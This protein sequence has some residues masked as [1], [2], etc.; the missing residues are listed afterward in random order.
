M[1]EVYYHKGYSLML[2]GRASRFYY[3]SLTTKEPITFETMVCATKVHFETE[4]NRQLYMSDWRETTYPRIIAANPSKSRL[5]CLQ[6]LYD[7]L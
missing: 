5:E 3:S 7:K 1:P 2:K 6:L 4:E